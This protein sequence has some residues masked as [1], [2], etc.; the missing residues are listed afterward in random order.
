M[1]FNR[2]EMSEI[3]QKLPEYDDLVLSLI[4]HYY[5]NYDPRTAGDFLKN[6][7]GLSIYTLMRK[8]LLDYLELDQYHSVQN[9]I[10]SCRM[11]LQIDPNA[12]VLFHDR[13]LQQD[14]LH[15][16]GITVSLTLDQNQNQHMVDTS[17]HE[18]ISL[19][20]SVDGML[21]KAMTKIISNLA[22]NYPVL[23]SLEL[24]TEEVDGVIHW[25]LR[26]TKMKDYT[27]HESIRL[28]LS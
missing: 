10:S 18:F 24:D 23:T 4:T 16:S 11:L 22:L 27:Y 14:Y 12:N 28:I 13:V 26:D 15:P 25:R 1:Y 7:V 19:G 6:Q 9:E 3:T 2:V 17:V 5:S 21:R 8:Q 20:I